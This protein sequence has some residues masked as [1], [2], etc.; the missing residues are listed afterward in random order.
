[1]LVQRGLGG[2]FRR[3]D[4]PGV[5]GLRGSNRLCNLGLAMVR[6]SKKTAL[7]N[8]DKV[9]EMLLRACRFLRFRG[10]WVDPN[11][12]YESASMLSVTLRLGPK[13]ALK[14][15]ERKPGLPCQRQKQPILTS[16]VIEWASSGDSG[17]RR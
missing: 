8:N 15:R 5:I 14:P 13:R 1:M 9:E 16:A 10:A 6:S 3:M 17:V 12:E 2:K 11:P 4:I 7:L